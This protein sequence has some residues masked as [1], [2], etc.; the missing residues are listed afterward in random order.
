MSDDVLERY[1]SQT[2]A[3]GLEGGMGEVHFA[4][5]GGEP[6]MLGVEYFRK[7]VTLQKKHLPAGVPVSNAFQT[8]GILLDEAWGVFLAE[9]DFLVGL[10]VD[11]PKA[12]HDRYR[13]DRAGRPTFDAVMRG[14]EVL[15]R[16]GLRHNALTTVHRGNG[17][18]GRDVYRFLTGKG[19]D[20]I[21]FIPIAERSAG[22]S[23]AGAPQQDMA[24]QNKVTDWSVAARAYGKCLCDVF[25]LW[26]KAD[27]GRVSV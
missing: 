3:S 6:T 13:L 21:Q 11:G 22:E 1:I 24:P 17:G 9:N 25:D 14:L 16:H 27:V 5:Q 4:W 20:H 10:S 7:I 23:L 2:I 19:L 26:F 18:K 15:Q 8:N 12:V